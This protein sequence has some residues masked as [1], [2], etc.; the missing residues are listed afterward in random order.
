[1]RTTLLLSILLASCQPP[2]TPTTVGYFDT[3]L[4][5][6]QPVE[7]QAMT[8]RT[9]VVTEGLTF[10]W[11]MA[12]LP[13]GTVLV[14]ER[15]GNLRV[16]ENGILRAE[17]V[18][19]L[20]EVWSRGQGGLLEV[21]LH[22]DFEQNRFIYLTY[23]KPM[24]GGAHTALMRAVFDGTALT[25]TLTLFT[26]GPAS[27]RGQHFGSRI[28]FDRD[29][30]LYFSI[31]DRG[32]MEDAQ[33]LTNAAGKVFRIH[34]DGRVPEDNPYVGTAGAWPQ[35]WTHGN[36]NIQGMTVHPE[37]GEIW[38]TEHGPMGGDELNHIRKGLNYGWPAISYGINY[39]GS[40]ITD[41]TA[42]A[43]MEQPVWMWK[44]SIGPSGLTFVSGD[45]YP[46]W[47]G[48]VLAGSLAFTDLYRVDMQGDRA[49]A[50]EALLTGI[51][52]VRDVRQGPDGYLYLLVESSGQ[53]I[54]LLP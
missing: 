34:D 12:F 53:L 46:G 51:G 52:R 45:K 14:T 44:P 18:R 4:P 42:R 41:D 25:D 20:P 40:I 21:A 9:Q 22:P 10:P 11:S 33:S 15:G 37:T 24:D 8:F 50:H 32:R 6:S 29:G 43:G 7:T 54:R 49:V 35:I 5:A 26:G 31:G 48:D 27:G 13:N 47:N 1:M 28:V 2:A 19:G 17:P 36:R 23:S 3:G 16:I 39:N 30:Y 38:A